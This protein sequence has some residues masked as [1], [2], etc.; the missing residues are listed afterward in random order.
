[1]DFRELN[2]KTAMHLASYIMNQGHPS[3]F[4]ENKDEEF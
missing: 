4:F 3:D 2:F 1:M